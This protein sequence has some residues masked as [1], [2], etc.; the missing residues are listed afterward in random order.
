MSWDDVA[1]QGGEDREKTPYT[2]FEKGGTLIRVLDN[3][4]FSFWSHWLQSQKTS[5]T[6]PGKGCPIC[7]VIAQMKAN[8]QTP[9]YT[10][11]QR[12]ALRIW[13]YKTEQMEV[14]IQGKKFFSDL[15]SLHREVGDITTYDIKVIRNGEG[16]ETTY[17]I[18]PQTPTEFEI[19]EG[20][21]DVNLAEL[22][23]APT[24]EEIMQLMEGKTWDEINGVNDTEMSA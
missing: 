10:S 6:C 7:N 16:T 21:E 8:K 23:H 19:T 17:M 22:L 2:K 24:N 15:L 3:E 13:N 9:I 18:L 5:I 1:R 11:T 14:L 20:I 4:P 12:H